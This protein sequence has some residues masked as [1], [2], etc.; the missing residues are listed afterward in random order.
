M[1][2][3]QKDKYRQQ[4]NVYKA[5]SKSLRTNFQK[6]MQQQRYNQYSTYEKEERKKLL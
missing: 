3:S 1:G 4:L 5:Q 2:T 6:A